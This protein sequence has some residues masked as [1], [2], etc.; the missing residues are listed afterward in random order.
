M[1]FGSLKWAPQCVKLHESPFLPIFEKLKNIFFC[2]LLQNCQIMFFS[3]EKLL[4]KK[5]PL[6]KNCSEKENFPSKNFL[7][8]LVYSRKVPPKKCSH[9]KL[10]KFFSSGFLSKNR[11]KQFSSLG[12]L[13]GKRF[14]LPWKIAQNFFFRVFSQKITRKKIFTVQKLPNPLPNFF[15]LVFSWKIIQ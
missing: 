2:I 11:S 6:F 3:L 9:I 4:R 12:K 8:F 5:F 10:P 13:S 15:F 7:N 14:F 1:S